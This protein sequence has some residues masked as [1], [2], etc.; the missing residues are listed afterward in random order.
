MRLSRMVAG[1]VGMVLVL[2]S[3]GMA[4]ASARQA[5]TPRYGGTVT[6]AL[7]S[8]IAT[9]DPADWTDIPSM[10]EMESIYSTLVT[11]A[12][13]ST[14]IVPGLATW[15]EENGGKTYIFH[16]N[17]KARFSNGDPVT[18]A[19]VQFSLNRVTSYNPTGSGPAPYGSSYSDIVGYNAWFNNGQPPPKGVTGLSGVKVLGPHTLEIDLVQPAGYF[20]NTLALMSA[21]ILDPAVVN[22]WGPK[23]YEYH[24]VGSGPFEVQSWQPGRQ[25]V[26]VPNPYYYGPKPYVSKVVIEENVP[27]SLQLLRFE[28][29]QLSFDLNID[30]GSYLRILQDPALHKLF[31]ER[32]YNEIVFLKMNL[33]HKLFQ[34]RLVRLALNYA[35]NRPE[36]VRA[37]LN[38][39]GVP[40]DQILPPGI[41]GYNPAIPQFTYDPAKA[42]ALLAQAGY[43]NGITLNYVYLSANPDL[44][45]MAEILQQTMA[46]AG[47]HLNLH[48]ISEIGT[49]F[50]FIINPKNAWDLA[51]SD[52]PQDYPN[53]QDFLYNLYQ[54]LLTLNP[55]ASEWVDT[56]RFGQLINAADALPA[57]QEAEAVKLYQQAEVIAHNNAYWVFMYYPVQDGLVQPWM[58]P[59]VNFYLHPVKG[60][61]F[62]Y[63]WINK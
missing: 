8:N 45:R 1:T 13:N 22:K 59:D 3:A 20:L 30:S 5:A 56:P 60:P 35:V 34:N 36:I 31:H 55:N 50:P 7:D 40:A 51:Y 62:Q 2:G 15:T 4:A 47:I 17:P 49:Y 57:S 12:K 48:P 63:M 25:M 58:A 23:Q 53:A 16:L 41:P 26:L 6:M 19:D 9:L 43:P 38:G 21:V 44:V 10:Y 37:V 46:P 61:Q 27:P 14:R 24:A 28:K 52:W 32:P 18:A 33:S 11:Y 29:G 39:L 42:K 54:R